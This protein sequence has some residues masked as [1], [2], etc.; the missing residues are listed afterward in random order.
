MN[1]SVDR[2]KFLIQCFNRIKTF[3]WNMFFNWFLKIDY[4]YSFTFHFPSLQIG[5]EYRNGSWNGMMS[6]IANKVSEVYLIFI[7]IGIKYLF[8][9][10][11]YNMLEQKITKFF[12][13]LN[14]FILQNKI[15]FDL[16]MCIF[17]LI[18]LSFLYLLSKKGDRRCIHW[19]RV[20]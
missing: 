15:I 1:N 19:L 13:F 11:I 16:I 9:N 20:R 2:F 14:L 5:G 10:F 4:S 7:S 17:Y 12:N 18:S 3:R 8:P 6:L